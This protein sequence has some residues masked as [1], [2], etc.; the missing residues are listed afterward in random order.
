M[1]N[2]TTKTGQER[3]QNGQYG[4]TFSAVCGRCGKTLGEH[5]AERP[6]TGLED[7]CEGFRKAKP[8]ARK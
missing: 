5:T 8:A 1:N 4:S 2:G 7:D 6:Y 3:Q